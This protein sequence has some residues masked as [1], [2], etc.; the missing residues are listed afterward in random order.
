MAV[1]DAH[2]FHTTLY[3]FD[4][5][6]RQAVITRFNAALND[7]AARCWYDVEHD[8]FELRCPNNLGPN[9]DEALADAIKATIVTELRVAERDEVPRDPCSEIIASC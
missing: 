9:A 7:V 8:L 4:Q 5:Q 2:Y 1:S 6:T 3:Q